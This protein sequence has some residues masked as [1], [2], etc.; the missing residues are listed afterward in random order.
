MLNLCHIISGDLWAG[1]EVM[2]YHLLKGLQAYDGL[3]LSAILLNEGRLAEEFR[4]FRIKVHVVDESK[5]SFLDTLLTIRRI[6]IEHPPDLI[7][8]HRYKENILAFLISRSFPDCKL[9][10]TQHSKPEI[11]PKQTSLKHHLISK[12]NFFV[13]SR[14][15]HPVVGVSQ[16]I[17]RTLVKQYG[18]REGQVCMIHNGIELPKIPPKRDNREK[19]VIGS[20]GRLFSVKDYPLMVEIAKVILK[21]TDKIHFELAG[22]GPERANIQSLIKSYRLNGVF[23]LKGHLE[24][25]SAFYCGLDLYLN[26]SI[27]EGIPMSILEAMANGLPVVAP[28]VGGL[29]EVVD[30]EVQGYLLEERNPEAF[31]EKCLYLHRN[32]ALRQRMSQAARERIVQSFSIERMVEQYYKLYVSL[33][34]NG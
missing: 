23:N 3:D 20:S 14:Y 18:F 7:H 26:T 22:E 15:F 10:V 17:G 5:T 33:T 16:E 2:A 21:K 29:S 9:M 27:N 8:S 31:A 1:A 25:I 12:C 11:Y 32:K 13:L 30:N 24:N 4:K 28:N 6:L 34:E 19:F